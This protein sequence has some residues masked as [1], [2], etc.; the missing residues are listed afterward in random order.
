MAE[1]DV[2]PEFANFHSSPLSSTLVAVFL[3]SLADGCG[4]VFYP[5][6]EEP[7]VCLE[8][9]NPSMV[10]VPLSSIGFSYKIAWPINAIG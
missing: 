3:K 7:A 8:K 10:P 6:G 4:D 5:F 1:V 9:G 2:H